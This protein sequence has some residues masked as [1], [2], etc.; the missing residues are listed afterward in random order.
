MNSQYPFSWPHH[1]IF[2]S[3]INLKRCLL[4]AKTSSTKKAQWR[5]GEK[6]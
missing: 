4:F 3:Y 2:S 6:K 1:F 5:E